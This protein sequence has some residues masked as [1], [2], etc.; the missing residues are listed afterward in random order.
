MII[1]FLIPASDE[2]ADAVKYYSAQAPALGQLFENEVRVAL[3]RIG[4]YPDAWQSS[5]PRA[6]RFR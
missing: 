1:R 5:S 4:L 6:R 3:T 2:L